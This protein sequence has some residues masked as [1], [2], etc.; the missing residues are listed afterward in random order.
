MKSVV[1]NI[2]I[3]LELK[4]L[5][6]NAC[7]QNKTTVSKL[8]REAVAFYFENYDSHQESNNFEDEDFELLKS[9]RF[10]RLIY[11]VMQKKN[12]RRILTHDKIFIEY[13]KTIDEILLNKYFTFELKK[14]FEKVKLELLEYLSKS[15]LYHA[16]FNFPRSFEGF[17][18]N[19]LN[20]FMNDLTYCERGI[21]TIYID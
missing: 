7:D 13:R 9:L 5:I 12:D 21:K 15:R 20:V 14:E 18:Y 10:T 8:V 16:E 3:S 4:H 11:W 17:D 19:R 2:R 6:N 1:I